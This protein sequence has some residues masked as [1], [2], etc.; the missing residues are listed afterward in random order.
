MHDLSTGKKSPICIAPGEQD[1]AEIYGDKIVWQDGRNDLTKP[2][3]YMRDLSTQPPVALGRIAGKDRI[4]TACKIAQAGWTR[5]D[6]AIL[7]RSDL[8]PD[9]LSGGP[10]SEFY[11]PILLTKPTQITDGT[12]PTLQN[13][14]TKKIIILGG[15]PAV[16]EDVEAALKQQGFEVER[17]AGSD[18]YATST[19][20]AKKL[21]EKGVNKVLI[22]TGTNFPDALAAAPYAARENAAILLTDPKNLPSPTK[23][24]INF[25]G[26]DEVTILGSTVAVSQNVEDQLKAMGLKVSRIAGADRYETGVK[27]AEKM[28]SIKL[29]I[30]TGE[31]FPDALAGG[32]FAI[33]E[34]AIIILVKKDQVP[35]SVKDYLAARKGVFTNVW[36]LGGEPAVSSQ[37]EAEIGHILG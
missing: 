5:S 6:F 14:Q 26:V 1:Y 21:K 24:A 34:D 31:N 4:E 25:L 27:I 11:C 22:A 2:D 8:F 35:Q 23:D 13:L 12:I 30:A 17:I 20:I 9:A 10:L 36:I 32:A 15:P 16:S 33:K 28:T 18:R 7:T 3:I 37:V 29:I 19:E